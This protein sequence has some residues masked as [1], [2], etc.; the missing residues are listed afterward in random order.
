LSETFASGDS[1]TQ[2]HSF[3]STAPAKFVPWKETA[4]FAAGWTM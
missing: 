2:N 3:W 4:M 1:W